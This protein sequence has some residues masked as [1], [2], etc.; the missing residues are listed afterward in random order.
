MTDYIVPAQISENISEMLQLVALKAHEILGCADFSRVDFM[1]D[2][3][4]NY[5]VLEINTILFI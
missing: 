3:Q 5:Y 2:A 4:Q 1:L